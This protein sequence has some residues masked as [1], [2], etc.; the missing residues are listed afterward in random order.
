[1]IGI[2]GGM[3]LRELMRERRF[4]VVDGIVLRDGV[5]GRVISVGT[6]AASSGLLA[7]DV[8]S[9]EMHLQC[10]P[11]LPCGDDA[12]PLDEGLTCLLYTSPSPRD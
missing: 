5:G 7:D 1:M 8:G 4:D 6:C 12:V 10:I 2:V 9:G 11:C 3:H